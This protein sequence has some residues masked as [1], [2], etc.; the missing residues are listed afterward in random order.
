MYILSLFHRTLLFECNNY[1]LV[2]VVVSPK[3]LLFWTIIIEDRIRECLQQSHKCPGGRSDV[4]L[5]Y[6]V[7]PLSLNFSL[8]DHRFISKSVLEYKVQVWL[9][10]MQAYLHHLIAGLPGRATGPVQLK[11]RAGAPLEPKKG[12]IIQ[13]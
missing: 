2:L 1:S 12:Q 11:Q 4:Y 13:P 9:C 3:S 8:K 7:L 6:S 10:T 5:F